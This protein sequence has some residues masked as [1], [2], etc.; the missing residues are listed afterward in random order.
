MKINIPWTRCAISTR[1]LNK[2]L[3]LRLR[4]TL[5]Y[6][7]YI[8]LSSSRVHRVL[9]RGL[10][11]FPAHTANSSSNKLSWTNSGHSLTYGSSPSR[12]P[13]HLKHSKEQVYRKIRH[14]T[15][16]IL[17]I[18]LPILGTT[19]IHSNC[20]LE[21]DFLKTVPCF[22]II[23]CPHTIMAE[24]IGLFDEPLKW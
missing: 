17:K 10:S 13:H 11:V 18:F 20:N 12:K 24:P 23:I 4:L 1:A 15:S 6:A 2:A 5:K 14:L 8:V 9:V 19:Q 3:Q 7:Q 21:N 22:L 16:S